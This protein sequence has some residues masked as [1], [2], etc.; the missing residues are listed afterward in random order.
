MGLGLANVYIFSSQLPAARFTLMR[1]AGSAHNHFET[2][3]VDSKAAVHRKLSASVEALDHQRSLAF[4][5]LPCRHIFDFVYQILCLVYRRGLDGKQLRPHIAALPGGEAGVDD[6]AAQAQFAAGRVDG[7]HRRDLEP[8]LRADP[9]DRAVVADYARKRAENA[10]AADGQRAAAMID[11][12]GEAV[13]RAAELERS[14]S[15][16]DDLRR[17]ANTVADLQRLALIDIDCAAAFAET[18]AARCILHHIA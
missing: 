14:F 6:V 5:K 15:L 13:A 3:A 4:F 18:D 8:A 17:A 11:D 12:A 10:V 9:P 2:A 7:I 1:Q 16:L